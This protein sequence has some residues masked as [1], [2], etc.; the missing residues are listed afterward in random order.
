MFIVVDTNMLMRSFRFI[1]EL[2]IEGAQVIIPRSVIEEIKEQADLE[3]LK[4]L[5]NK[6]QNGEIKKREK[7][8]ALALKQWPKLE[9]KV[10]NG[11]WLVK[12]SFG[13][14][15]VPQL[16]AE[17][18]KMKLFSLGIVD[19]RVVATALAL[20]NG[21]RELVTLLSLDKEVRILAKK[22]GINVPPLHGWRRHF[23]KEEI[24]KI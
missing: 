14:R 19:I 24:L 8:I 12:G 11:E 5:K 22:V 10:R 15:L 13:K 3:K 1:E 17:A 7:T 23:W 21:T 4:R 6:P 2:E 16:L 20:K 18:Q 9:Q